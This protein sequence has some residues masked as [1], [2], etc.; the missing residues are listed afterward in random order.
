MI[1]LPDEHRRDQKVSVGFAILTTSDSRTKEN[2]QTGRIAHE[3]ITSEHHQVVEYD[4]VR[5]RAEDILERVET[6]L[7]NKDVRVIIT[8]GGTGVGSRDL[9]VRTL[10][11]KFEKHLVGFGEL[12]RRIS[13][14]EIGVPGI[15]SQASAGLIG[16]TV[17]YCLPGS[18]NAMRTALSK[19]ILPGIGHLIWEI[20]R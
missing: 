14:D 4:V 5:N 13:Y 20:D 11:P 15:Y 17:I 6:Y 18:K 1:L 7:Q 3:L 12:F 8:S 9:T 16:T 19:I 2:D 10:M